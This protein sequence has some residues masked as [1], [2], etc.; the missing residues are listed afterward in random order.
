MTNRARVVSVKTTL[1]EGKDIRT[2]QLA[3]G[4]YQE[5]L[6]H[7]A[8]LPFVPARVLTQLLGTASP[9][10]IQRRLRLLQQ[11]GVARALYVPS[12][13]STGGRPLALWQLTPAGQGLLLGSDRRRLAQHVP[14]HWRQL[15]ATYELLGALAAGLSEAGTDATLE[16][17]EGPW[18]RMVA[19]RSGVRALHLPAAAVLAA[20]ADATQRMSL[21]LLQDFGWAPLAQYRRTLSLLAALRAASKG[22]GFPTL[23]IATVSAPGRLDAWRDLIAGAST[24]SGEPPL[25]ALV[26]TW[27]EVRECQRGLIVGSSD[28]STQVSQ[29][30]S[31][32]GVAGIT[33]SRTRVS[34]ISRPGVDYQ[35]VLQLVGRHPFLP[36]VHVAALL[37]VRVRD[38]RTRL[39]RLASVGLLRWVGA[40]SDTEQPSLGLTRA[41][42]K[43]LELS[44]LTRAGLRELSA[45][46]GLSMARAERLHGLVGG[47]PEQATRARRPLVRA[48]AHTIGTDT[49][50]VALHLAATETHGGLVRWDNAAAALR[51]RC[52]P[53][54]YAVWR[55][56][57]RDVGVFVEYD[58]GTERASEYAGK[59]AAYYEFRDDRRASQDYTSFPTILVV[60]TASEEPIL[61]SARAAAM[62]R[63]SAPLPILVTTTSRIS[64]HP[65]GILGPIWRTPERPGR[66]ALAPT[67]SAAERGVP[68]LD[69]LEDRLRSES[70]SSSTAVQ[71]PQRTKVGA[72]SALTGAVHKRGVHK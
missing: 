27:S 1:G 57:A 11:S 72:L 17:W 20:R 24:E 35:P 13:G 71:T 69:W 6:R 19:M 16:A 53:D 5:L 3:E 12:G 65:Q 51:G 33:L 14:R 23:V 47:G 46:L 41:E 32:A 61:R 8:Q 22:D 28:A 62:G 60:T 54:G 64:S 34:C 9:S 36:L 18:C 10:S 40:A 25:S 21:L 63:P 49:V 2:Q 31:L 38:A 45:V 29:S 58:R 15:V 26:V 7:L 50:F 30:M 56:A 48:L 4:R 68:N 66:C 67:A 44:E 43:A 70:V 55:L 42:I 59:W 37:G 39:Q 52:R